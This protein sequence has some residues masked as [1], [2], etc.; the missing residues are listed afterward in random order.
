MDAKDHEFDFLL[1]DKL[2]DDQCC[3]GFKKHPKHYVIMDMITYCSLGNLETGL[4]SVRWTD[5]VLWYIL[6][7][8]ISP[9]FSSKKVCHSFIFE[10][11]R[12]CFIRTRFALM[13]SHEISDQDRNRF[14]KRLRDVANWA[15]TWTGTQAGMLAVIRNKTKTYK[16]RAEQWNKHIIKHFPVTKE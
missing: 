9:S 8:G 13:S 6:D 1:R 10:F 7:N 3:V 16:T 4:H 5:R 15:D 14:Y 2:K 11:W 12:Y